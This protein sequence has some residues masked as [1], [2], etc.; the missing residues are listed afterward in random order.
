MT[1]EQASDDKKRPVG[2]PSKYK[3]EYCKQVIEWGKQGYSREM[4]AGELDV[5]WNTL[6][7]WMEAHPEFLE[8]LESAKM[9]EMIYFEKIG[10]QYMVERPQG[11]KL[12]TSI[13]SRSLAARFPQ[14]Y[15][16]NT[17]VEVTGKND[18]AIQVDVVHDF[19]QELMNDLLSTRQAG[20]KSDDS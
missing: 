13:W 19:A 20:D 9:Q 11:D 8:A 15:R 1:D 4:I 2:R 14:K 18:G 3:P 12:N 16:E 10:I 5:S 7:S 6:L 17:K